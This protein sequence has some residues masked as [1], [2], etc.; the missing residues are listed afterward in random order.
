MRPNWFIG[1][2]RTGDRTNFIRPVSGT[3]KRSLSSEGEIECTMDMRGH[4]VTKLNLGLAAEEWRTYLA[5]EKD[6]RIRQA[7]PILG[8]QFNDDDQTLVLKAGGFKSYLQHRVQTVWPIVDLATDTVTYRGSYGDIAR[9][10]IRGMMMRPGGDLPIVVPNIVEGGTRVRTLNNFDLSYVGDLI[11]NLTNIINGPDIVFRPR[12]RADGL[13]VEW[14]MLTGTDDDDEIHGTVDAEPVWDHSARKTTVRSLS[15]NRS[16]ANL[17]DEAFALG[18][19]QQDK[20]IMARS[21]RTGLRD[22]GFPLMQAQLNLNSVSE[23][24]TA[25]GYADR[26]SQFGQKS[27]VTWDMKVSANMPPRITEYQEGDY[28]RVRVGVHKY[29]PAGEYRMR[30]LDIA[31]DA[32]ENEVTLT[33]SPDRTEPEIEDEA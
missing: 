25:Q 11:D 33:I 12:L 26:Q 31:S 20:L 32:L 10:I 4:D 22:R 28:I 19:G 17:A 13:G 15:V 16:G 29:I 7:G 21:N 6:G 2:M 14:E 24:T 18:G 8:H 9:S 3:W 5:V 1:E 30:L 27:V 23:I